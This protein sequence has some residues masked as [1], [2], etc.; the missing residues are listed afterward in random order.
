[1]IMAIV[2]IALALVWLMYETKFMRIRLESTEYQKAVIAQGKV[3]HDV[4]HD[5]ES[6]TESENRTPYKPSEFVPADM[7]EFTGK[8]NIVCRIE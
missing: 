6:D 7:P 5:T 2:I 8:L 3:N 4:N 1:M